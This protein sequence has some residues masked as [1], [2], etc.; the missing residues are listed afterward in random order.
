M[1]F[2]SSFIADAADWNFQNQSR[3]GFELP[4]PETS[5]ATRWIYEVAGAVSAVLLSLVVIIV[6]VRR[7]IEE[8]HRCWGTLKR[9][10]SSANSTTWYTDASFT[11]QQ[12]HEPDTQ[13]A[14][15]PEVLE[16]EPRGLVTTYNKG[17]LFSITNY[18]PEF[19]ETI[20]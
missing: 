11:A 6:L 16:M 13:S 4:S 5:S 12:P 3:Q 19:N 17:R 18:S 1:R 20:A 9:S 10:F 8:C 14:S 7:N 2:N 15:A